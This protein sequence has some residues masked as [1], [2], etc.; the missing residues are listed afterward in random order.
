MD[1]EKYLLVFA[2]TA[3]KQ[4]EKLDKA[5][6][7]QIIKFLGKDAFLIAPDKVGKRL[8][9]DF[10]GLWR[11]HIGGFRVIAEIQESKKTILIVIIDKRDKV[12]N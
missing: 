1:S 8:T 11:Y 9:H 3:E 7:Q 6:Q 2:Q 4:F 12:Y 10:S 5:V